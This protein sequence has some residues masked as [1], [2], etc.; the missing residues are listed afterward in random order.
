MASEQGDVA[1]RDPVDSDDSR[2]GD[3]VTQASQQ[4]D[5]GYDEYIFLLMRT[6][7]VYSM[8]F[9]VLCMTIVNIL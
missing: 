9:T 4:A 1:S 5:R 7:I 8:F 3:S 2:R 6:F